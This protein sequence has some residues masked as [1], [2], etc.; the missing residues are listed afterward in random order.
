MDRV[1]IVMFKSKCISAHKTKDA[2]DTIAVNIG[3]DVQA[4]PLVT[5]PPSND[6]ETELDSEH[7]M[8]YFNQ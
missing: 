7:W 3:G 2:A 1:Y 4:V 6:M 8:N 5:E